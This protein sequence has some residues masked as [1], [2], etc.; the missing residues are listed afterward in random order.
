MH[1]YCAINNWRRR[2]KNE[3]ALDVNNFAI[4]VS[5]YYY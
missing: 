2:I 4:L 3:A 1:T 5:Y